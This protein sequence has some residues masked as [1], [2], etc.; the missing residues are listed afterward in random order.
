LVTVVWQ[1]WL[2]EG[3]EAEG[4]SIT[5]TTWAELQQFDAY[6]SHYL[7]IDEDVPGHL[8][9]VSQWK[10]LEGETELR[11]R[12]TSSELIRRLS[13]LLAR[14]MDRWVVRDCA[15]PIERSTPTTAGDPD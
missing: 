4:L 1:V 13:L 11:Q 3:S 10:T 5:Q 12:Y 6:V 2:K 14:P 7:L 15:E 8:L 9:I